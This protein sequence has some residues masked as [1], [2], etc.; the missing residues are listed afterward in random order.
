M[1][2]NK[3]ILMGRL[4][5]APELKTT[6]NGTA[7]TSFTVAVD[8]P[9]RQGEDRQADFIACVAWRQTAEFV[10]QYF[11]K[12]ALIALTGRLQTRKYDDRDGK[13]R[14]VTEVVVD[15]VSFTGER[16]E[17]RAQPEFIETD[18]DGDLSF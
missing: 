6:Q 13:P 1:A 12:G 5:A 11:D 7:V 9:A 15:E 3:I 18:D 16:K 8:R 10:C 4:T 17:T 14:T 2:L